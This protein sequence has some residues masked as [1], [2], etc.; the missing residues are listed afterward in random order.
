M[1]GLSLEYLQF[2]E[3]RYLHKKAVYVS[4]TK[5]NGC[6]SLRRPH[7]AGAIGVRER[8]REKSQR[9]WY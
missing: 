8:S 4:D 6:C 7:S 2:G 5:N 3:T 1:R 9:S